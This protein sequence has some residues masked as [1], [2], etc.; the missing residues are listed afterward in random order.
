MISVS[1][2]GT[3]TC[4]LD[5]Y[6]FQPWKILSQVLICAKG[7]PRYGPRSAE[8]I[9]PEIINGMPR[10]H[11]PDLSTHE[12]V[13][14]QPWKLDHWREECSVLYFSL[15]TL[16]QEQI[17]EKIRVDHPLSLDSQLTLN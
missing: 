16:W 11:V 9:I 15:G 17:R 6:P 7:V 12:S 4:T 13:I 10:W 8:K 5:L 2:H 14:V 3:C 1:K